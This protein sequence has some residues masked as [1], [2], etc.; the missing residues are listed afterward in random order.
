MLCINSYV[1][2]CHVFT[3]FSPNYVDIFLV[4][5]ILVILDCFSLG[6]SS[7]SWHDFWHLTSFTKVW[8]CHR[9]T[10]AEV[11]MM[12]ARIKMRSCPFRFLLVTST[13]QMSRKG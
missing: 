4:Y 9:N 1:N 7:V 8:L 13:V 6:S 10:S 12:I 3:T 2:V 5:V 11:A